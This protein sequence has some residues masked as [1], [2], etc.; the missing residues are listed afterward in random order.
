M[1]GVRSDLDD[2]RLRKVEHYLRRLHFGYYTGAYSGKRI[3]DDAGPMWA[4]VSAVLETRTPPQL[5][6]TRA[7]CRCRRGSAA[8]TCTGGDR[9]PENG[10][11]GCNTGTHLADLHQ[12]QAL[13]EPVVECPHCGAQN[14]VQIV[15]VS[16]SLSAAEPQFRGT[17]LV[18]FQIKPQDPKYEKES[19]HCGSC[20]QTVV[21]PDGV[22]IVRLRAVS[23]ELRLEAR[24]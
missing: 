16:E 22:E 23:G 13:Q 14:D 5:I 15:S 18:A 9:G 10:G 11:G 7:S 19:W 2:V 17:T 20:H 21:A 1:T 12:Q 6:L 3:R 24:P 4:L 8:I